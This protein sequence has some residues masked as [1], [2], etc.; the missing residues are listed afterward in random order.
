[1]HTMSK[2]VRQ[3]HPLRWFTWTG[4]GSIDTATAARGQMRTR[5]HVHMC[6]K[7]ASRPPLESQQAHPART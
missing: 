1:M 7:H 6:L 3:S 5:K 4:L 2:R